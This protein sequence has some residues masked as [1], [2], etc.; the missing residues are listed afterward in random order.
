[1]AQALGVPD[2]TGWKQEA[3]TNGGA[4]AMRP[5]QSIR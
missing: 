5:M 3:A 1:M 2:N 4:E